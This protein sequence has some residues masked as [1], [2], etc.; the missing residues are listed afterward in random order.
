M[1]RRVVDSWGLGGLDFL[2]S[3]IGQ[4]WLGISNPQAGPREPGKVEAGAKGRGVN[5]P[6]RG[7]STVTIGRRY[8]AP[9]NHREGPL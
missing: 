2:E 6:H 8:E 3:K 1:K 9:T 5:G 7:L 4:G